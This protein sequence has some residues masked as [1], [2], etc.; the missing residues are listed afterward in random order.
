MVVVDIP[1]QR[2]TRV[3]LRQPPATGA[4]RIGAL[5]RRAAERG[6]VMVEDSSF[7]GLAVRRRAAERESVS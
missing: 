4:G 3:I 6:R 5:L 2:A 1:A 7:G